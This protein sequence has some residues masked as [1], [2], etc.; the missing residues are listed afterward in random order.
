MKFELFEIY[1]CFI[2]VHFV[3][4]IFL[5]RLLKMEDTPR[6]PVLQD[7]SSRL[8]NP[9]QSGTRHVSAFKAVV[10]GESANH[11]HRRRSSSVGDENQ[12]HLLSKVNS[13]SSTS[14]ASHEALAE[15]DGNRVLYISSE[16]NSLN[17]V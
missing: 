13:R 14:I 16:V 6:R 1:N 5:N 9:C 3:W 2:P 12:K 17:S 11:P 15:F 10:R 4:I 8:I 7:I